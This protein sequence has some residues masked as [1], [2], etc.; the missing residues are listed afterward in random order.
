MRLDDWFLTDEERGNDATRLAAWSEHNLVRPL[1]HGATYFA[2][3]AARVADLGHDD[4]LLFTDWRGD[5]DERLMPDGPEV[6]AALA[7]AAHQGALVRGLI[8]HSHLDALRFSSAENRHL[9][10]CIEEAGGQA[11]LD[12]RVRV[13]G[14]HH[15]KFVVLRHSDD[16]SRDV[17]Y[18]GGIDLCHSRRDD[19]RHLGDPQVAPL[20]GVYGERPAWHDVQVAISGPAVAEVEKV[21]RERWED[22]A[23]E[24]RQPFRRLR[25]RM[26]GMADVPPLPAPAPPPPPAGTHAVQLLRTYPHLPRRGY[27]FAPQGERSVARAYRK[28]LAQASSLIY[29]EDQYLWS[30][31]VIESFATALERE[32]ELRMIVVVPRYPDEDGRLTSAAC[33]IGRMAA[34]A[35]LRSAGGS[36]LAIYDLENHAGTPVYVHAKVCVV[37]DIWANVGSDN[38]NL[39]SWTYDSELSCAVIDAEPDPRSPSG[40]RKYARDL[41]L[42]L[43]AE[44]LDRE[45]VDDLCEPKAVFEAFA[46]SAA[47][48]EA[49]HQRGR[50]GDRPPGRLR[51][52]PEP[53]VGRLSKVM[54][55]PLYHAVVDPDGRPRHLRRAKDF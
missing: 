48:L 18:V 39:R 50:T 30:A 42:T 28:V 4:L 41:R 34:L 24:T 49:W 47:R 43:A 17:A 33:A 31:E 36:R 25:D 10:E 38:V 51:P 14:S 23:P 40:A 2:D 53:K 11:V 12:T 35:R 55:G 52:H 22:P 45:Y 7:R 3:L 20:P 15:Q 8:W 44:H 5:P 29:L 9:G 26:Q 13:G 6:A 19:A 21:F 32:P 1:I 54:A 27:P 37:D 16:S 46:E